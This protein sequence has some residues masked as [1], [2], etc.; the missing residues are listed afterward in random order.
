MKTATIADLRNHFP[1]VFRW[2]EEGEQ[3]ELTKRGRVV[4]RLVPPPKEEPR[5]FKMPD[6]KAMRREIFG[7]NPPVFTPEDSAFIHDRGDR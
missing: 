6:F 3:V 4:A 7:D 2:I 5:E 1:R